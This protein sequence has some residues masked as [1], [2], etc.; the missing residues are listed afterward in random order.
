MQ[1]ERLA[2][3]ERLLQ[4]CGFGGA[5]IAPLAADASFRRYDRISGTDG[6]YAV[7]MDAPPDKED[8]RPFHR[9]AS[10]LDDWNLSAPEVF[11]ADAAHGFLLLEDLGD[12]LFSRLIRNGHDE[13]ELYAAA[14]DVLADLTCRT[15]PGDLQAYD[16]DL[17]LSETEL[18]LDWRFAEST[19]ESATDTQRETWR[20]AWSTAL[21]PV[22]DARDVLVL[23]DYHVDNL[24]WLPGRDGV[25]RTG[26]LD[27][28]DAVL[29]HPAYDVASLLSDVRRDVSPELE[30]AMLDRYMAATGAEETEFRNAYTLLA[31]QRNA[32]I[33]GIFT[34]L[35][36]R[37]GKHG[38]RKWLPRTWRL[39]RR[40][41]SHPALAPVARWF[42][43]HLPR[44]PAE[45]SAE[46]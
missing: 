12:D 16:S 11:G 37:D 33:I 15:P 28:Q 4:G 14:I 3:R 30:Q 6:R 2:A 29:G 9:V 34:R 24:I 17:L 27:F 22:A 1:A 25:R 45:D 36:V 42:D 19:G 23:R 18:L 40:D 7:L 13:T 46:T 32:K 21:A 35:S 8:V 38:Y 44:D 5:N 43:N 20:A 26:L 31:A 39:L 10:I 41:L